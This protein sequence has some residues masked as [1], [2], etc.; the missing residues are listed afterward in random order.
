M[1]PTLVLPLQ[2]DAPAQMSGGATLVS[3][4]ANT[5]PVA[6][7]PRAPSG[8]AEI[9][10]RRFGAATLNFLALAASVG[11]WA[12]IPLFDFEMRDERQ[13]NHR[14]PRRD[15]LAGNVVE[16]LCRARSTR[17]LG[18]NYSCLGGANA[19]PKAWVS[20]AGTVQ[21]VEFSLRKTKFRG[22]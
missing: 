19:E 12:G 2:K 8:R 6:G 21:L 9:P 4:S 3:C 18:W 7:S 14:T 10:I 22:E 5:A 16:I 20:P 13:Q 1:S 15:R 11:W 17:P